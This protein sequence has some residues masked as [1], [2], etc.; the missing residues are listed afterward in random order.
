MIEAIYSVFWIFVLALALKRL[1]FFMNLPGLP[2]RLLL[3]FFLAK[4]VAGAVFIFI[5]TYYY[6]SAT[7][8][9]YRFFNEGKVLY[10]A[11]A[12]NPFDYLRMMTGIGANAP[13]LKEYFDKMPYWWDPELYPVYNDN[14]LMI[15][16]NAILNLL[17]FGKIHV[18]SVIANFVSLAGLVAIYKFALRHIAAE[19]LNWIKWGVFLFPSMVFWGS[20]LTK[21]ALLLPVMG[22]FVFY[23]DRILSGEKLKIAQY[24]GFALLFALF[25][26]L[27]VYVLLLLLPC[28]FAFSLSGKVKGMRAGILFPA[29]IFG[30]AIAVFAF[31]W[32]FPQFDPAAIL[33]KRQNFFMRFSVFVEAGSLIHEVYLEPTL[34]SI[35]LYSP[36]AFFNVMFR[37]HLFESLNPVILMAAIENLLILLFSS[38]M[39]FRAFKKKELSRIEW[40]G[41]WFTL[42]LFVFIGLTTQVYGTLVRFKIPALP[43]FWL[44]FISIVPVEKFKWPAFLKNLTEKAFK[45]KPQ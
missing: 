12:Q 17:S 15:R 4:V 2:Y 35:L 42:I 25:L 13:H 29:I 9:I 8:D 38:I 23:A 14:R 37:P 41:I 7:A 19:K 33:A 22:F 28:L 32:L 40:F 10:G 31:G 20:G 36:R 24:I 16:Y 44:S 21:E 43:F 3:F 18:N 26:L 5:Y 45:I 27:K 1:P 11:L 34:Q 39:A 30:A 6:D